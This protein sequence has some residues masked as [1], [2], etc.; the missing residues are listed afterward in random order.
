MKARAAEF[1]RQSRQVQTLSPGS[2]HMLPDRSLPLVVVS[3]GLVVAAVDGHNLQHL[4]VRRN[5]L[6]A[7]RRRL[8]ATA[9]VELRRLAAEHR[10]V[11]ESAGLEL[12]RQMVVPVVVAFLRTVESKRMVCL[13]NLES[14]RIVGCKLGAGHRMLAELEPCLCP[15]S[16]LVSSAQVE[17][18]REK[19]TLHFNGRPLT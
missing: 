11:L 15:T 1:C 7:E 6:V 10:I 3:T 13:D 2:Q 16:I 4:V 8:L 17:N 5:P 9:V 18:I 14:G 19:L 12:V